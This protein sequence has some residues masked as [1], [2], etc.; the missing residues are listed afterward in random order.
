MRA[1]ARLVFATCNEA[2]LADSPLVVS[3]AVPLA[4]PSVVVEAMELQAHRRAQA[5]ESALERLTHA[6]SL[7][8]DDA[9]AASAL[10]AKRAR[11][12]VDA[13]SQGAPQAG[14]GSGQVPTQAQQQE[15]EM[16]AQ[17][18]V[19]DID[20]LV[21]AS[22]RSHEE[23][24]QVDASEALLQSLVGEVAEELEAIDAKQR[25]RTRA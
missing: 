5:H 25:Q 6:S 22:L 9:L 19:G 10:A 15:E 8:T 4:P 11:G 21:R 3:E 13:A 7:A 20:A 2:A 24:V 16:Y 17:L 14:G 23:Q 18:A 1:W 12:E